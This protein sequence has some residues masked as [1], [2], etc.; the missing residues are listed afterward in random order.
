MARYFDSIHS[1]ASAREATALLLHDSSISFYLCIIVVSMSILSMVIF[2]CSQSPAAKKGRKIRGHG[3]GK[4][5]FQHG[6]GG[7][8]AYFGGNC[9]GGGGV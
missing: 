8:V 3:G 1:G 7:G 5:H 4:A 9:G 6:H 2:A